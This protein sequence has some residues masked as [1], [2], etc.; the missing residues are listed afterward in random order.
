MPNDEKDRHVLAAIA[1]QEF[2]HALEDLASHR[3]KPMN[4]IPGMLTSLQKTVPK[5]A[6]QAQ[7]MLPDYL[8]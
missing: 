8:P 2:F 1:P 3:R 7:A 4:S 5:F 6:S